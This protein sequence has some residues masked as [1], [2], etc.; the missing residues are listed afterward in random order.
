M[1]C[2]NIVEVFRDSLYVDMVGE[3]FEIQE[4][5]TKIH[6]NS[7]MKTGNSLDS[8]TDF[9]A[10]NFNTKGMTDDDFSVGTDWF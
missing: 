2:V 9:L 6:I 8:S 3:C 5:D 7:L 4:A 10:E 1:T